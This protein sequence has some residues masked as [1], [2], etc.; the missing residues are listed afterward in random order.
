LDIG[1]QRGLVRE[2]DR[3]MQQRARGSNHEAVARQAVSRPFGQFQSTREIGFPDI[4]AIYQAE[5]QRQT[6]RREWQRVVELLQPAHEIEDA[7]Q[8]APQSLT[9]SLGLIDGRNI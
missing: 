4:S 5:R 7:L 2:I 9:L 3:N 6:L 1:R 8:L